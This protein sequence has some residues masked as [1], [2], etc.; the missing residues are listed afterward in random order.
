MIFVLLAEYK[1]KLLMATHEK[2]LQ[3][4]KEGEHAAKEAIRSG[5]YIQLMD[6]GSMVLDDLGLA[7]TIGWNSQVVSAENKANK[8]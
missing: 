5:Q 4:M 6:E 1:G 3:A 7:R 2:K 8:P